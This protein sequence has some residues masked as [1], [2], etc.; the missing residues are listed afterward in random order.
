[1]SKYKENDV[2]RLKLFLIDL[3]NLIDEYHPNIYMLDSIFKNVKAIEDD[4]QKEIRSF[5][6]DK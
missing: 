1:M 4:I 2:E 6:E 3:E 5:L